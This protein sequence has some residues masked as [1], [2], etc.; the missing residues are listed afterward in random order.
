MTIGEVR[1]LLD[2]GDAAWT[3]LGV[4]G[5][6][7]W[8]LTDKDAPNGRVVSLHPDAPHDLTEIV[9]EGEHRITGAG[10]DH[11]AAAFL[12]GGASPTTPGWLVVHRLEHATSRVYVHDLNGGLLHEVELPGIGT[13]QTVNGGRHDDAVF[14]T[15]ETFTEPAMVLRHDLETAV[16]T[17][18]HRADLP[19]SGD[20]LP[21]L[22]TEQVFVHHDGE[23]DLDGPVKVPVF[24]VHRADVAPTG[25]VPTLLWGYGGFDISVPPMFKVP[26]RTWVERGGTAR[27]RVSA[28]RGRVRADLAPRRQAQHNKQHAFDDALAVADWLTG[29]TGRRPATPT[30]TH[31]C[32]GTARGPPRP[33]SGS[34]GAP[35]AACSSGRASPSAAR[36][37]GRRSRRS[38]SSTCCASTGSRSGGPGPRTTAR[39]DD[40][41]GFRDPAGL[42]A[43]AQP[44]TTGPLSG[45]AG[46]DRRHRR[47]GRAGALLQ[48]RRGAAGRR[49]P[50][51]PRSSS[52]STPPPG[53]ERA[54]RCRNSSTNAPT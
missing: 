35:T 13:V 33:T 39:P 16:T 15:F 54:S 30:A 47:P 19:A 38:A 50:V 52:A 1:P 14:L 4:V 2:D 46:H 41:D 51:T 37:S 34:R 5:E 3:F 12:I 7:F 27:G 42:V 36:G 26:W 45:H 49:R 23:S 31:C 9:A 8:F 25:A 11:T 21:E 22:V 10:A 6:R 28:G 48:V 18:V 40:P 29:A 17:V 44:P 24:L 20:D 43:A 53:T 32:S